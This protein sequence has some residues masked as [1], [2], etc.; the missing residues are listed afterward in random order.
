VEEDLLKL[1]TVQTENEEG[2]YRSAPEVL[3]KEGKASQGLPSGSSKQ[4]DP[5]S[6]GLCKFYVNTG[7]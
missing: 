1:V 3:L 6:Q 5:L 7:K 4:A 2:V